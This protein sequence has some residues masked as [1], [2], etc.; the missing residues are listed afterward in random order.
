MKLIQV[1]WRKGC[2]DTK[3]QNPYQQ[4]FSE[5]RYKWGTGIKSK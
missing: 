5:A 2:S 3:L 4:R 1:E